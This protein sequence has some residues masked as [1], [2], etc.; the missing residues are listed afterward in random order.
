MVATAS[1]LTQAESFPTSSYDSS[2]YW[3]DVAFAAAA[4]TNPPVANNDSGFVTAENTPLSIPAS[5]LLANDT[6]PNGYAIS[7]TGVSN[8]TGGTVI[9]NAGTQTITFTPTTGYGGSASFTYT[10]SN[11]AGLSASANVSLTISATATTWS[12]F[13]SSS[14]PLSGTVQD[15]NPVELGVKFQ[16]SVAGTITAIRFYKISQNTGTHVANLWTSGGMLLCKR[17]I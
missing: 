1:I 10:I 6:D 17:D 13:S 11:S 5:A 14:S 15:S 16:S 12:L 8:P 7:I 3:V 4:I 9:L 2:N